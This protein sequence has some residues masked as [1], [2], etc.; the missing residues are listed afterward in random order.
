[1][2]IERESKPP[3]DYKLFLELSGEE[4]QIL[5]YFT[6]APPDSDISG[7]ELT[8]FKEGQNYRHE[9][10]VL[11]RP[12]LERGLVSQGFNPRRVEPVEG[13]GSDRYYITDETDYTFLSEDLIEIWENKGLLPRSKR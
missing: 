4:Q 12:L 7:E 8:A 6:A 1:M 11:M 2:K 13:D 10:P 5:L 3:L 9:L